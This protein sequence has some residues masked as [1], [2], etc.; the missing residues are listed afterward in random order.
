MNLLN[1][2]EQKKQSASSSCLTTLVFIVVIFSNFSQMASGTRRCSR[3]P[4]LL[5]I[6]LD[7]FRW[8]YLKMHYLPAFSYLKTIG[9]HADFVYNNF[10]T[11]TYPNHFSIVTGLYEESHGIINTIMYD[12]ALNKTFA[13]EKEETHTAEWFAQN[14]N[15]EPIWTT[16]QLGGHGRWSLASWPGS[17]V[18]YM[19]ESV[20][21]VAFNH[22][23]DFKN[24]INT[25]V[26]RFKNKRTPI[27]FGAIYFN[28][29][30]IHFICACFQ[31]ESTFNVLLFTRLFYIVR[32][33]NTRIKIK[34]FK[35]L[36]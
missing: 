17:D 20:E 14:K 31:F 23:T 22:K 27:N 24:L 33:L 30:G 7:G 29:P 1:F 10:V 9:S 4:Q 32:F 26:R 36:T 12:R 28:Q 3:N 8:D 6:S 21:E 16:N 18:T 35:R 2:H 15:V 5:L 25:F 19:N 11:S 13:L 34:L